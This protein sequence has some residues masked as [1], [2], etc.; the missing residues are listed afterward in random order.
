[1]NRRHM[2]IVTT[3]LLSGL[4]VI[5][6][7]LHFLTKFYM[8]PSWPLWICVSVLSLFSVQDLRYLRGCVRTPWLCLTL[9]CLPLCGVAGAL[10]PYPGGLRCIALLLG[11]MVGLIWHELFTRPTWQ[12]NA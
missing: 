8:L 11:G 4:W 1:M 10:Y 6:G 9:G 3:L 7:A 2:L 5:I 12:K